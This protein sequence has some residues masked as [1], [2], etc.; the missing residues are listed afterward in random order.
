MP[1]FSFYTKIVRGIFGLARI[2]V[3]KMLRYHNYLYPYTN[4]TIY[5]I[6]FFYFPLNVYKSRNVG[7]F[8]FSG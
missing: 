6:L 1:P 4:P 5:F 8:Q 3:K 7:I 2:Y